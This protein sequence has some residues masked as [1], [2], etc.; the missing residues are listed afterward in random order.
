MWLTGVLRLVLLLV[1]WSLELSRRLVLDLLLT[2]H[3]SF[4]GGLLPSWL[5]HADVAVSRT[6]GVE[7]VI[8]IHELLTVCVLLLYHLG[9]LRHAWLEPKVRRS[10]HILLLWLNLQRWSHV[11]ARRQRHLWWIVVSVPI[12]LVVQALISLSLRVDCIVLV[13]HWLLLLLWD[14]ILPMRDWIHHLVGLLLRPQESSFVVNWLLG[15]SWLRLV[16][17]G[18]SGELLLGLSE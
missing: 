2:A 14:V 12:V 13:H 17:P 4:V 7:T 11:L 9:V 6:V 18:W 10:P 3:Y 1:W 16:L 15:Q 5:L 8:D